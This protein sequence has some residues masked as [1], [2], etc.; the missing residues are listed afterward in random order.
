MAACFDEAF[1]V[2]RLAQQN[3]PFV[4]VYVGLVQQ[5]LCR[6]DMRDELAVGKRVGNKVTRGRFLVT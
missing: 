3:G 6:V 2:S 5:R 4:S 1:Q